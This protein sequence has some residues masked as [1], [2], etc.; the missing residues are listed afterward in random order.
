MLS[1]L[2]RRW[3]ALFLQWCS[4]VGAAV[5]ASVASPAANALAESAN[6]AD[7]RAGLDL[8]EQQPAA[9]Q[10]CSSKGWRS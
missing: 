8:A 9:D 4:L 5:T 2:W 7:G 3:Q 6:D 10:A 1:H